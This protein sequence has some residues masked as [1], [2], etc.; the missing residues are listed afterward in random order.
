MQEI[1]LTFAFEEKL[2]LSKLSRTFTEFNYF[3]NKTSQLNADLKEKLLKLDEFSEVELTMIIEHLKR[4]ERKNYLNLPKVEIKK[5]SMNSPLEMII[6]SDISIHVAI[7]FLGGKRTGLFTYEI[8][9]GLL[10]QVRKFI[11][12]MSQ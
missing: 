10:S 6:Y 1:K 8:P 4:K 7:L 11:K 9:E 12:K 2:S 5:I 3:S